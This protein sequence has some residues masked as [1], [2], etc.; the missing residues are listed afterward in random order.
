MTSETAGPSAFDP[1]V[2]TSRFISCSRKSS[3]RPQGSGD[4][5][6]GL[7]MVEMAPEAHDLLGDVRPADELGDLLGDERL[8]GERLGAQ[9]AD[10]LEQPGLQAA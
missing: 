1:A 6:E 8:I 3:L 2:L 7:P 4:S 10:P 5:R 9:L